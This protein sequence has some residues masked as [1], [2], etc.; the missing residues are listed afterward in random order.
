MN[1]LF[2]DRLFSRIVLNFNNP[3]SSNNVYLILLFSATSTYFI[4]TN[5]NQRFFT[6]FFILFPFFFFKIE[7]MSNIS[8]PIPVSSLILIT[9]MIHQQSTFFG[10][11]SIRQEEHDHFFVKYF[12]G[13]SG[14]FVLYSCIFRFL[15]HS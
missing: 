5:Y 2:C 13:R 8:N 15:S 12:N 14:I 9:N 7:A 3:I 6:I 1:L 10:N 11:A 4:K